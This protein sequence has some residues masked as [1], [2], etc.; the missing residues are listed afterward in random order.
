MLFTMNKARLSRLTLILPLIIISEIGCKNKVSEIK[1]SYSDKEIV[2]TKPATSNKIDLD[3]YVDA[4]K[5]ME[6]FAVNRNTVYSEFL[7]HL[8]ISVM[9]AWKNADVKFYK[10]GQIVKLIERREFLTSKDNPAFYNEKGVFEKTYI[11]SVVTR[12]NSNRL[13]VL[14]TDL[15]QDDGDVSNM[16]DRFKSKCFS[17]DVMVG[18][19]GMKSQ[20]IG[21][22]FDVPS[23]PKGYPLNVAERPFYAIV[24]GHP[25][26]MER[27]FES[28][29]AKPFVKEENFLIV[30]N[31]IMQAS[32]VKLTKNKN[33]KA[34]T[35]KGSSDKNK[36]VF[37]FNLKQDATPS[38]IEFDINL[39]RNNVRHFSKLRDK[40]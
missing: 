8:D 37:H 19:L 39:K 21:Q 24:F 5:S 18:L 26:N 13:S 2:G 34:L 28:L 30:S 25:I 20:F 10:F 14:I 33:S 36:N 38:Q 23:Y 35:N 17:Q 1:W 3:V 7:D 29:K 6:G 31:T 9:S 16:I 40:H 27:L 12:T 22:V 15:F 4:T 11:D 32:D